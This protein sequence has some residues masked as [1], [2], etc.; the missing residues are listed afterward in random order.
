MLPAN[1]IPVIAAI[2]EYVDRP[3]SPA[4]A[5]EP[6]RLMEEALR[7]CEADAGVAILQSLS[8]LSLIGLIS[9]RYRDP[10]A[11]LCQKLGISPADQVN[12]SMGGE[13]PVR[14]VHEAAVRIAAGEPVVAAITGGEAAHAV[15]RARKAGAMPP[16]TDM[17]PP[18]ETIRF[19]SSSFALSPVAKALEIWDPAQIYPFYEVASQASWGQTP[20]QAHAASAQ[21]WARYAEVAAA[22]PS[23]WIRSAPDAERI[24]AIDGDN[25]MIN[26][27]YPKLMVANPAVNQAAAIVVMSLEK[28][29][30]LGLAERRLV[31]IWG[32]AAAREP[33]DYLERDRYDRSTAQS[34]VLEAAVSLM[35][36]GRTAFDQIELYSCFPVVPKMA[37]RTLGDA[38]AQRPPS[39]AGGLTFFGGPLNNYMGHAVAA[40]VRNLRAAPG[41]LGLLY[42]QGGYMNKHHALVIGTAPSGRPIET[43]YCVQAEADRL[44]EPVPALAAGYEGP[45]KLETYTV[46]YART[47]E[48]SQGIVIAQ[49]PD[50]QRVMARVQPTDEATI[51][52]LT[53]WEQSA[54]GLWG[55]VSV[56]TSG[57]PLFTAPDAS[58]SL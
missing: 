17:P 23:A 24:A 26:W 50:G 25:R 55:L 34:A 29:R 42:G 52:L 33:E 8:S 36:D 6:V 27:P 9:W 21:L 35:D 47:G 14:L 16:W 19:P 7:A 4:E 2:G 43:D 3:K 5:L 10:A 30:E 48:P 41:D 28:A 31:H 1:I 12:A 40:M 18:G 58:P 39:V 32:G 15:G 53:D 57:T 46:T 11:L 38:A 22:N 37:L 54:V 20:R 45:V 56:D 49:T 51:A 13:T 44:R